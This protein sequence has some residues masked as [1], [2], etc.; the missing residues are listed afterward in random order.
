MA[1]IQTEP[2]PPEYMFRAL[3]LPV[4]G[5]CASGRSKDRCWGRNEEGRKEGMTVATLY[6]LGTRKQMKL[7]PKE[8]QNFQAEWITAINCIISIGYGQEKVW[9]RYVTEASLLREGSI[10]WPDVASAQLLR[11]DDSNLDHCYLLVKVL[12]ARCAHRLSAKLLPTFADG[13]VSRSQRRGA[14]TAVNDISRPEPLL[15]H[16]SS[17]SIVLRR[18]NVPRSGP[19]ATRFCEK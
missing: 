5:F 6:L 15:F 3:P 11:Q 18:L 7:K 10:S 8:K 16:S 1:L 13:G 4:N 12:C 2:V 19:G 17:S 14:P 9:S